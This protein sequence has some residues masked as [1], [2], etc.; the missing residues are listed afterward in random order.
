MRIAIDLHGVIEKNPEYWKFFMRELMKTNK[1]VII[2]GR[3]KD[4]LKNEI[5]VLGLEKDVHY[6][7]IYSIVDHLRQR[8][9]EVSKNEYGYW[10]KDSDWWPTKAMICQERHVDLLIDD[11]IE[12]AMYMK[13]YAPDCK[14]IL[15]PSN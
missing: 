12:Y 7:S 14:F 5:D 13:M 3:P 15:W 4:E 1:V 8:N 6:G 9:I 10:A 2:S 11:S